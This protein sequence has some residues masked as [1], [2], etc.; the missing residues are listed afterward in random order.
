MGEDLIID[1]IIHDALW[2]RIAEN[3]VTKDRERG[4]TIYTFKYAYTRKIKDTE[5]SYEINWYNEED[6]E[7]ETIS[8]I[9]T[10]EQ[11]ARAV[12]DNYRRA[13]FEEEKEVF[14]KFALGLLKG[15]SNE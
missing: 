9:P 3:G 6:P 14:A 10:V 1:N 5:T 8:N 2:I 12:K 7:P 4:M 13:S 15:A 11:C